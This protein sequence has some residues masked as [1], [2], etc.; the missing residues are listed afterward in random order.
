M[1]NKLIVKMCINAMLI[2]LIVIMT[3]VPY[4]GFIPIPVLGISITIIHVV[5]LIGAM[6]LGFKSG[7][8]LGTA[9]GVCSLIKALSYP[10]T[11]DYLFV[12]PLVSILPR[13]I[14]GLVSGLLFDLIRKFKLNGPITFVLFCVVSGLMTLFHSFL[15]LT[16][17]Y[18]FSFDKELL[19]SN[20]ITSYGVLIAGIFAVNALLEILLAVIVTPT[21]SLALFKG[22]PEITR[23]PY[24]KLQK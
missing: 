13:M 9:F 10:G 2:A 7:L 6:I 23:S 1:R 8:L 17:L 15:T 12:N 5:V 18:L 22:F 21:L 11:I 4:V 14:F 3:F 19:I 20:G 16:C 24:V